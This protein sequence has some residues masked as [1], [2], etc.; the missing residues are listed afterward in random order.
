MEG[1]SSDINQKLSSKFD[2]Y[3]EGRIGLDLIEDPLIQVL[4]RFK[5][6][7]FQPI[8]ESGKNEVWNNINQSISS[9]TRIHSLDKRI[10]FKTWA[11]A[12]SFLVASFIGLYYTFINQS[13]EMILQTFADTGTVTLKDGTE[14]ILRP[15]SELTEINFSND[16]QEYSL[17]GEG[18]FNVAKKENREFTVTAGSGKVS[19]LGTRFN[20]S[21]WGGTSE[22]YLEEGSVSFEHIIISNQII[23]QPGESAQAVKNGTLSKNEQANAR[24]FNDWRNNQLNFSNKDVSSII[25]ELEQHFNIKVLIP[26]EVKLVTLSGGLSLESED[27]SL[28][29]LALILNGDFEM[30]KEKEYQFISE[31]E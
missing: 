15:Y 20:L 30:I 19:V 2:N 1:Q 3:L 18:F 31:T 12:A 9:T 22:V 24:E 7:N 27:R 10:N 29:Y 17:E 13:P 5:E 11:V 16:L 26:E 8:A 21:N 14:V 23:L 25:A 28:E 6:E 4:S